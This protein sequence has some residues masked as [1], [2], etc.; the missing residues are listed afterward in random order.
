MLAG[1]AQ[2]GNLRRSLRTSNPAH[3]STQAPGPSAVDP[4]NMERAGSWRPGGARQCTNRPDVMTSVCSALPGAPVDGTGAHRREG[5]G[6][7]SFSAFGTLLCVPRG[8]DRAQRGQA[9]RTAPH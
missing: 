8:A 5:K 3:H 7:A 1:R 2:L 9:R 6:V 4:H